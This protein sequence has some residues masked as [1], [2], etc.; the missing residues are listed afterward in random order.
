M[1]KAKAI[2]ALD[3]ERNGLRGEEFLS[4]GVVLVVKYDDGENKISHHYWECDLSK[5]NLDPWVEENV[6]PHMVGQST[7]SQH[8]MLKEFS[9]FWGKCN[10]KFEITVV[11]HMGAPVESNLFDKLYELGFIGAFEGPYRWFDTNVLLALN[12]HQH[13]SEV[14]FLDSL[15]SLGERDHKL[16]NALD[17]ARITCQVFSALANRL[18]NER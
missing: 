16:H 1:S 18:Y 3:C 13:D 4:I 12:G 14:K 15:P 6:V 10:D 5:V 2:F 17:D 9:H 8:N 11:T 7:A